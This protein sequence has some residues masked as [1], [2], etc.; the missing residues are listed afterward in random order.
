MMGTHATTLVILSVMKRK[1]GVIQEWIG[2]AAGWEDIVRQVTM[3]ALLSAITI[4]VRIQQAVTWVLTTLVVGREIIVHMGTIQALQ[5]PWGPGI[6]GSFVQGSAPPN[7]QR[8]R[9]GVTTHTIPTDVGWEIGVL[10]K[11][12]N[13]LFNAL[14]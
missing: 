14:K 11:E 10:Q 7:V 6:L 5:R 8:V 3:T 13:A 2:M 9:R 4:A 1:S 12:L